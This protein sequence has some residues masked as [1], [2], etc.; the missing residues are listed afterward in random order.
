LRSVPSMLRGF[1]PSV[2]RQE[3]RGEF[4]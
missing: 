1:L 3:A 4:F 2:P